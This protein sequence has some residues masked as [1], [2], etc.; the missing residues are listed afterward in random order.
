MFSGG[1]A[2]F[3]MFVS[4]VL[5]VTYIVIESRGMIFAG[6]D[7]RPSAYMVSSGGRSGGGGGGIFYWGSGYRGGK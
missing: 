6:S 5:L 7:R 2:K 3:Y 1:L 4:G